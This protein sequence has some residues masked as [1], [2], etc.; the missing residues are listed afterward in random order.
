MKRVKSLAFG[1]ALSA[2]ATIL[3]LAAGC[4]KAAGRER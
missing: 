4:S 3:V 2:D 1:F